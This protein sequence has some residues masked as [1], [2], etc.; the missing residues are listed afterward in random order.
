MKKKFEIHQFKGKPFTDALAA[1]TEPFGGNQN[2]LRSIITALGKAP[3]N[4]QSVLFEHG[5]VDKDY[6]DEYAAYYCKSFKQYDSRCVRLHFFSCA[7]PPDT[8]TE[9]GQFATSYLGYLVIR[10]TDLQRV[11]RTVLRT[12]LTDP[13]RQFFHCVVQCDTHILG[14]IF[15]IEG[16]PFVQQDTQVGACAQASLWMLARYMSRK[17]GYREY[18]PSEINILAKSYIAGG[19]PLPAENGLNSFQI[20]DALRGMGIPALIYSRSA[21]KDCSKHIELAFPV[22]PNAPEADQRTQSETQNSVKLADIT[23]RYI[24]SGLPVIIGTDNHA[25][26]AIGHTYDPCVEATVAIQRIPAFYV[27]NDN[28]GPYREMPI[29]TL[30][31]TDYSFSQAQCIIPVLPHEV[32]LRGEEAEVMAREYL[33]EFLD[34]LV[35]QPVPATGTAP[36]APVKLRDLVQQ[37]NS[38]LNG[39]LQNMEYRTFLQR[40]VDFQTSLRADMAAG[41]FDKGVGAELLSLDYPKYVWITEAS[42]ST[43]LNHADKKDRKCV[44]RVIVDSTAPAK[45]EGVMA[46]HAVDFLQLVG[47]NAGAKK[48][49]TFHPG[50]TPF[51]HKALMQS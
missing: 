4:C 35:P 7:I 5:Y 17:F 38:S 21:L 32:T 15:S 47:R 31:K 14:E 16:M 25:L 44:G 13:N 37:I 42:S 20:L 2:P 10:P 39:T 11:G 22:D 1:C 3:Y 45:T 33:D 48:V 6:Q 29:F 12:N 51:R 49:M 23:Y 36:P 27:N 26:V 43:L 50:S 34:L 46:M 9:F 30:S 28:T 19:R 24:E 18:L 41:V 40:S 8:T